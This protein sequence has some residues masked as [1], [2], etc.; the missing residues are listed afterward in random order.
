MSNTT[1]SLVGCAPEYTTED[2][3][4]ELLLWVWPL[5]TCLGDMGTVG[6]LAQLEKLGAD[7]SSSTSITLSWTRVLSLIQF[8]VSALVR[9][10]SDSWQKSSAST[11]SAALALSISSVI[12]SLSRLLTVRHSLEISAFLCKPPDDLVHTYHHR[13]DKGC[14]L[15]YNLV[16][17]WFFEG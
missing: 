9:A 4:L 1:M 2:F 5:A 8:S 15:S 10:L 7:E 14:W 13:S 3:V 11:S 16:A 12:S 6:M 17:V